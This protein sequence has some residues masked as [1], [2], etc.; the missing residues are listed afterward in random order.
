ME[1]IEGALIPCWLTGGAWL[2]KLNKI[3]GLSD[4][5]ASVQHDVAMLK[6]D[7]RHNREQLHDMQLGQ[8]LLP[9]RDEIAD[10][11]MNIC[12]SQIHPVHNEQ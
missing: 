4:R 8:K 2:N 7:S 5:V 12:K 6:S 10:E 9:V 3:L 1:A 11:I